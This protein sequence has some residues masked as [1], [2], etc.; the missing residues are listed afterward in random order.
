LVL[1]RRETFY[2]MPCIQYL[3]SDYEN[4]T[5]NIKECIVYGESGIME[6]GAFVNI[7]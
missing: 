3:I 1:S 5:K 4:N 6:L 2:S 7:L